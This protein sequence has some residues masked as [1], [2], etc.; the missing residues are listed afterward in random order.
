MADKMSKSFSWDGWDWKAWLRGNKEAAKIVISAL[1]GVWVPA[2]PEL[3]L[4]AG[5][6]LKLVLDLIDFWASPVSLK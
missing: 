6:G 1:F 3:K 2:T 4:V 5:A